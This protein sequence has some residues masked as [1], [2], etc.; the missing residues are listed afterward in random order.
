MGMM[1]MLLLVGNV[2]LLAPFIIG[3][4]AVGLLA[5]ARLYLTE[6]RVGSVVWGALLGFAVAAIMLV[7]I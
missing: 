3:I 2:A 6:C 4:V 5:T 7:M 1:W